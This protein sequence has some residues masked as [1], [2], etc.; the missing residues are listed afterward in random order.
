ML[1]HGTTSDTDLLER[2]VQGDAE[3]FGLLYRRHLER[4]YRY[5]LYRVS[6]QQ[7]AEDLTE[8]VFLKVWEALPGYRLREQP[9]TAWLFRV[10]E[11]TVIDYYRTR[12]AHKE[13]EEGLPADGPE[14]VERISL[15]EEMAQVRAALGQLSPDQQRLLL[16]RFVD[17]LSHAEV[18]QILGKTEGNVRVMQYRALAALAKVLGAMSSSGGGHSDG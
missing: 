16:L 3:A 11:N 12:H 2:A 10:A 6:N 18:A 14:P 5:V 1:V 17:G 15:G 13:L 7:E 4:V 9:W 8:T